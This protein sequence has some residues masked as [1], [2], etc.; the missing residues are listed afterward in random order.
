MSE[1]T[2]EELGRIASRWPEHRSLFIN[3]GPDDDCNLWDVWHDGGPGGHFADL[4]SEEMAVGLCAAI[5]ELLRLRLLLREA[6]T[7][8]SAIEAALARPGGQDEIDGLLNL[9]QRIHA[10]IGGKT[11][12]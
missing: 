8:L 9:V 6:Y 5:D 10:E 11:D 1:R 12:G 3:G 7:E 2:A 4:Y